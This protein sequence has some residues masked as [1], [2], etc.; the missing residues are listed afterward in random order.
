MD[1]KV[2]CTH[3][4]ELVEIDQDGT[5]MECVTPLAWPAVEKKYS[6]RS[7]EREEAAKELGATLP[8]SKKKQ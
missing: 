1:E 4:G 6:I 7:N 3:C 8:E 5:C 2:I